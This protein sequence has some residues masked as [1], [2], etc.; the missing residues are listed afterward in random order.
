[1][2]PR[3]WQGAL[4]SA[5]G[6]AAAWHATALAAPV[7]VASDVWSEDVEKFAGWLRSPVPERQAAGVQGLS[8]LKHWPAEEEI[9]RLLDH[10][11]PVVRREALQ[12]LG[13][14]GTA[15]AVPALIEQLSNRAWDMRQEA[16]LSLGRMTA[17]NFP[18]DQPGAWKNWWAGK[19]PA[20]H[21]SNLWAALGTSATPRADLLRALRH[22]AEA[23][24]EDAVRQWLSVP[25]KPPIAA[26]ERE[27]L[28]EAL[29]R[30]GTAR[31]VPVL[32]RLPIEEAAWALGRIGG[33]EAE[34]ALWKF[35]L[36]L[37][38]LL[39][40]DRL[41]S[42]NAAPRLGHL[43]NSMGLVT[44][45]SQPDDLFMDDPQPIQRVCANLILRA[46]EGPRLV[47]LVLRELEETMLPPLAKGPK[48]EP[49]PPLA[50]LLAEMRKELKPGFVREDGRTVS[51]PLT[52]MYFVARDP[53][54]APR[55]V[56]LLRHPAFVPRIYVAMT[57]GR[58]QARE[59]APAI[60][61]LL[62]EPYPFSDATALA[63]GK[64]FDQSQTVRWKGF[65]CLALGRMGGEEARL[66]L[67]K[68]A[69]DASATRDLRY[70]AVVGLGFIG[71]PQS[72]PVLRRVAA[73]DL[74]WMVRD[75]ARQAVEN[76]ELARKERGT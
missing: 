43:V 50:P 14:L 65:L 44:Y 33:A 61:T 25:Q 7:P 9:I 31:S 3:S 20:Q 39:N 58:L 40:L 54:L 73:E 15:R 32:A 30:I 68:I 6:L 28:C 76:I 11:A 48:P 45:R 55:L 57:L 52:A 62:R 74:I 38:V 71:S 5:V 51:Q 21:R 42:T 12:A 69:A 63:S 47:E 23:D 18:A 59:T 26:R 24:D 27:L 72:L 10:P 2:I 41:R 36:T 67:E 1:M 4:R 34:A 75:T 46:G 16:W 8:H 19:T 64:H 17:Q 53:A 29:E 22:L 60:L 13:R 37:P 66:A 49:P 35:P 56:P 70:G